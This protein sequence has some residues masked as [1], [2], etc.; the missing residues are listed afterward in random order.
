MK[1][2]ILF[3]L[4]LVSIILFIFSCSNDENLNFKKNDVANSLIV[5]KFKESMYILDFKD[6]VT[7]FIQYQDFNKIPKVIP[8]TVTYNKNKNILITNNENE[9]ASLVLDGNIFAIG[10]FNGLPL[11]KL[12]I[13]NLQQRSNEFYF[14]Y[15]WL[16]APDD[17]AEVKCG[18]V[19]VK[20]KKQPTNCK[21]GGPSSTQCAV[22]DGGGVAT[23]NWHH[24]CEVTCGSGTYAC[25]AVENNFLYK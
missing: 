3:S 18:C 16:D 21:G 8:S 13:D 17:V 25:C 9:N 20:D 12:S 10:K 24:H 19:G 4:I 23:A 2:L 22:T 15:P 6:S 7:Y 5:F 1:K 14:E 11:E